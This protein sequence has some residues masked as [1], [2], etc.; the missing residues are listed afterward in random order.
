MA[1]RSGWKRRNLFNRKF[2]KDER[3]RTRHFLFIILWSAIFFFFFQTFVVSLG[4][5][6]GDS[7]IPTL[8]DGRRY[9]VN[10]YIYRFT[11]PARGDIVVLRGNDYRRMELVKRIIGLPGE[12]I[13]ISDGIVYI[14]NESLSEPYIQRRAGPDIA[15]YILGRDNYFVMGDNRAESEDSRH[16]G[17][18]ASQNVEGKIAPDKF[19]TWK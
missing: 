19:F 8:K 7:M 14:N 12:N 2:V 3:R 9:L 10:K 18:V 13:R 4:V 6:S 15:P 16:F 17:S 11:K 5:I 1:K